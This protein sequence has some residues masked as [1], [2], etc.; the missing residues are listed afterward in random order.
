MLDI[1]YP[2]AEEKVVLTSE[3]IT[4][5]GFSLFRKYNQFEIRIMET[6]AKIQV[7]SQFGLIQIDPLSAENGSMRVLKHLWKH[8]NLQNNHK[9][10]EKR[11]KENS[12][13]YWMWLN[14][15]HRNIHL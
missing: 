12:L 10:G 15:P 13:E 2:L 8:D 1:F 5:N 11:R 4:E 6:S 7:S 3:Y 14:K 9:Q